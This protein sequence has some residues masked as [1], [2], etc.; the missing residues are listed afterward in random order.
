MEHTVFRC[1]DNYKILQYPDGKYVVLMA[2]S[3]ENL[4]M[5]AYYQQQTGQD[6]FICIDASYQYIS[7]GYR[8]WV[9]KTVKHGQSG[10][11]WIQTGLT[12]G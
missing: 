10:H 2:L 6:M 1:S 8:L 9:V 4:L 11:Y 7:E 3:A 12:C 5:N